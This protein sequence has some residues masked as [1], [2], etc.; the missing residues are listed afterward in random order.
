[1][2]KCLT[3]SLEDKNFLIVKDKIVKGSVDWD[4]I[5]KVSTAHFVFPAL[6]CNLKRKELLQFLPEDLVAYMKHIITLNNE[7]NLQIIQQ[8]KQLDFLLKENNIH[9]VFLKGTAFLLQG[10]YEEISER[11]V[12]DIDFIVSPEVYEDTIQI[13]KKNGYTNKD[14]LLNTVKIGNHYPRLVHENKIAAVEIH[15]RIL[16]PPYDKSFTYETVKNNISKTAENSYVLNYDHQ[17]LHTIFNKQA[18]DYGYWYKT[19]SLRNNYDLFLLSKK[20]NTLQAIKKYN[21]H[22]TILNTFLASSSYIFNHISSIHFVNN[23]KAATFIKHQIKFLDFPKKMNANK[24]IWNF[25]FENKSRL[26][27]L[28]LAFVNKNMRKHLLHLIFK[29]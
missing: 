15:F 21:R 13:L 25:Y 17:V 23:K 1:M 4:A 19:I 8:A 14:H 12:G 22:F 9:P 6:Y 5:V 2:A 11:M 29:R 26:R 18:S 10:F 28:K 3:I 27:K 20:T 7:R 24:K 16:K